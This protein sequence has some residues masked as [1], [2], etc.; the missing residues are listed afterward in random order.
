VGRTGRC[1]VVDLD[2]QLVAL[3]G[4]E[5]PD[6]AAAHLLGL[7]DASTRTEL[8]PDPLEQ[9]LELRAL[10]LQLREHL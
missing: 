5:A 8:E 10:K 3:P 7:Q 6:A 1:D 4:E 9:G 2:R